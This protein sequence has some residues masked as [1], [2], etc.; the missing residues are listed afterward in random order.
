M[1]IRTQCPKMIAKFDVG[2]LELTPECHARLEKLRKSPD[3]PNEWKLFHD[4]FGTF[5]FP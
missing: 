1:L 5:Y 2:A 4:E 3:D